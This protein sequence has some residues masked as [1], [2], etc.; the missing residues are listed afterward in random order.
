MYCSPIFTI[1]PLWCPYLFLFSLRALPLL[2]FDLLSTLGIKLP[3]CPPSFIVTRLLLG[4]LDRYERLPGMPPLDTHNSDYTQS[5]HD[6]SKL[7]ILRLD[8]VG[9]F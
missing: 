9:G 5:V 6:S 2:S 1:P 7:R 4:E 3:L 8:K